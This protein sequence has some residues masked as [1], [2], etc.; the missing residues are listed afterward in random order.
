MALTFLLP[1]HPCN[2]DL[3]LHHEFLNKDPRDVAEISFS[4]VSPLECTLDEACLA[5]DCITKARKAQVGMR[6]VGTSEVREIELCAE[7]GTLTQNQ[8]LQDLRCSDS[9]G[10]A[11][12]SEDQRDGDRHLGQ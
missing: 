5:Q 7:K 11:W 4:K 12:Q 10:K 8:P 3:W 2:L 9:C 1:S 6:K